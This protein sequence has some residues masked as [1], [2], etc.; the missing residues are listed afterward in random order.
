MN[1]CAES[2]AALAW[3]LDQ[4]HAASVAGVIF[5]DRGRATGSFRIGPRR[6]RS[7]QHDVR[8][9]LSDC[10][11]NQDPRK[12]ANDVRSHFGPRTHE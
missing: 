5:R 3:S 10:R 8:P 12:D 4:E 6:A 11:G 1:L 2:S 7:E 9:T